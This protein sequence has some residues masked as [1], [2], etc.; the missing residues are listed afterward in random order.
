[1]TTAVSVGAVF[2]YYDYFRR[3]EVEELLHAEDRR[4]Y[5]SKL[6]EIIKTQQEYL[7]NYMIFKSA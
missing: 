6:S 1:M 5:A 7:S 3:R 4:R 2:W